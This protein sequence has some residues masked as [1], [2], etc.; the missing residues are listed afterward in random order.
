[1]QQIEQQ[2][3]QKKNNKKIKGGDQWLPLRKIKRKYVG[4]SI[5]RPLKEES[6]MKKIIF[7]L[8]FILS[9]LLNISFAR[10]TEYIEF[11]SGEVD[12]GS[13]YLD[14]YEDYLNAIGGTDEQEVYKKEY[15]NMRLES[16]NAYDQAK[17]E[18][19]IKAQVLTVKDTEE[20]YS[21]D[22]YGVYKIRYQPLNIQILEGNT[23]VKYLIQPIY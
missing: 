14:S 21:Y 4:A 7:T 5:A 1:M 20:Y 18:N 12:D 13:I 11:S 19:V 6:I 22:T 3:L 16:I 10:T 9:L 2:D 23:R 8:T 15:A 17:A